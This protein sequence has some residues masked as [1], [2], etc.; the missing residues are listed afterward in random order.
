MDGGNVRLVKFEC[1]VFQAP[2]QYKPEINNGI[3]PRG[4]G[5][6]DANLDVAPFDSI[7]NPNRS[8]GGP[9]NPVTRLASLRKP[10]V[11]GPVAGN[12]RPEIDSFYNDRND[13]VNK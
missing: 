8:A 3:K 4:L 11:G 13:V 1:N 2:A 10:A 9:N 5:A 12:M 7:S 6:L